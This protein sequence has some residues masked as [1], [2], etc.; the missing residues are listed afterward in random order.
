MENEYIKTFLTTAKLSSFSK[1][2]RSLYLTPNAVKKRIASFERELGIM[3][4]IRT[5]RG[6]QLT[7][8][9]ESLYYE[10]QMLTERYQAAVLQA[11]NIA[12]RE[13]QC[14][15][16]GISDTFSDIFLSSNWLDAKHENLKRPHLIRYGNTIDDLKKMFSEVGHE[17][18]IVIDICD[19][20]TADKYRLQMVPVSEF[21]VYIG[22]P[23]P[24]QDAEERKR[25]INTSA[26]DVIYKGRS[27][28]T[29][30]IIS[31][32]I[33]QYPEAR[34]REISD[35]HFW[36]IQESFE[37]GDCILVPGN[38]KRLF[39][40]YHFYKTN[41]DMKVSFG[42]YYRS[43]SEEIRSFIRMVKQ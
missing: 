14:L 26:I 42:F 30:Q 3:L 29:D 31:Y 33:T 8:A 25:L 35:I 37:N 27:P 22:L 2:S 39:P 7:K 23:S 19:Q 6:V 13:S 9:G 1:A 11:R 17:S 32:A 41:L 4:F 43:D 5:N 38:L 20:K 40:H 15:H 28:A 12:E 24:C 18:D 10:F 36:T 21:S 16:I 34:I